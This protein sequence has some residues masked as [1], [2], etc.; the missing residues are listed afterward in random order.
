MSTGPGFSDDLV[1]RL[2]LPL[3]QLYRRA[4]AAPR[5]RER[6]LEGLYLWEAALRLLGSVALVRYAA[7][8]SRDRKVEEQLARLARPNAGL[9]WEAV[10]LLVPILAEHGDPY[11]A[12]VRTLLFGDAAADMPAVTAVLR[13]LGEGRDTGGP[14]GALERFF[15][16]LVA[17]RNRELGHGVDWRGSFEQ[18]A[19]VGGLLLQAAAEV[20]PRLDV[21]AGCRLLYLA[22]LRGSTEVAPVLDRFELVGEVPVRLEPFVPE[23]EVTYVPPPPDRLYLMAPDD[24]PPTLGPFRIRGLLPFDPL[25]HYDPE[26]G[27]VFFFNRGQG[28]RPP[29][30]TCYTT[31]R[32]TS[33][34]DADV[35][36]LPLL[37]EVLAIRP[38]QE[39]PGPTA[40]DDR[41]PAQPR[42]LSPEDTREAA[43]P[44]VAEPATAEP[45]T[46]AGAGGE[47]A[48]GE[49]A[50][51]EPGLRR[52]GE[53]EVVGELG[54]GNTGIVL[55]G[56][57]PVLERPVALK[58][59]PPHAAEEPRT[60]E[61]FLLEVRI[62]GRVRHPSLVQ[63]Y[64]SGVAEGCLFCAMEL[65]EGAPLSAVSPRLQ[66]G[67]RGPAG[68]DL[69]AWYRAVSDASRT[70]PPGNLEA[71]AGRPVYPR[72]AEVVRQVAGAAHALHRAGVVHR[73]MTP[74]NILIT[75]DGTRAVLIGLGLAKEGVE[76]GALTLEGSL[77]GTPGYA[78]PEQIQADEKR[79]DDRSDVYSL[80]V[81]LWELLTLRPLVRGYNVGEI[82]QQVLY[83]EPEPPR[84]HNSRVPADLEAVCLRCLH[85]DRDRRYASAHEL[86]EDL[87]RF[88]DGKPVRARRRSLLE[89]ATGWLRRPPRQ[90][91]VAPEIPVTPPS[92]PPRPAPE[93]EDRP[94]PAPP[95]ADRP[96]VP[97]SV[98]TPAPAPVSAPDQAFSS[99]TV[100]TLYPV[101][102]AIT[103]RR[104]CQETHPRSRL[105][106]LFF[107]L[108]SAVRYLLTLGVSDLFGVLANSGRDPAAALA[109]A[110]FEFLRRP[111]PMLLGK[112]VAALRETA[113]ALAAVPV[114]ERFVAELPEVCRPGGAL[115]ADLLAG[116]VSRRNDCAHPDGSIRL[117][118]E[119]CRELM[120]ECRPLLEEV[121]REVRFICRYPLGFVTPFAGLSAAPGE[122]YYHLHSCMGTWVGGTS[123]ALDLKTP[124]ELREELPFVAAPDG[125]R[126][127]Y[128]WPMLLQRR[129]EYTGR[130]T[131]FV[132]Q[133]IADHRRPFLASVRAA[134]VDVP[135]TWSPE[136]HPQPAASHAWLLGRL[137][138]LPPA[139][140]VPAELRLAERL[141]PARGGRLVGQEVG[142]N[143]LLSV[144]AVGGFGTVYAAEALDGERV[145]VKVIESRP[146]PVQLAR[147]GQEIARL[148]QAADHPGVIRLFEH[149]DVDV[150]GRICPWYSMEF[151]LGGD[152]RSR[153]DRRKVV[154]KERPPWDDPATRDEV[155]AE[156]TAVVEAVAHLH[157]LRIVHRDVKPGNVLI[158]G[159]GSLRLSD[160]GLVKNLQPSDETLRY[161]PHSA[162]GEGAGTPGYMAPE[163]ARGLDAREPAD[164]YALGILLAELALGE[165]PGAELP[166]A[167]PDGVTPSGSTLRKCRALDRLPAG[168]R[169]LIHR[170]TDADPEH[171]PGDAGELLREFVA[172]PGDA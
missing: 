170:C 31:G 69:R 77:V 78:S 129:S 110:D 3:A 135:E 112:W 107:V 153:I 41:G 53:F 119:K 24:G 85:K 144:V 105:E 101:P 70:F 114:N 57:Q 67:E 125:R 33:R 75:A 152:L 87:D 86:A 169:A 52:L 99:Q 16:A 45:V 151:A 142:S 113:R 130:R 11:F 8:S 35:G 161:G 42:R 97:R 2:P 1:R 117:P 100:V 17:Y 148:R 157:R 165:R 6:H 115:D 155:R 30:Y 121:L 21:L 96:T 19:R 166:P 154:A 74:H 140:E 59:L 71:M 68:P 26:T 54:R 143:R 73:N 18:Y 15:V 43:P 159:D 123:R 98:R 164:V 72:L 139:P 120:R 93:E 92:R 51:A 32:F 132:F 65:V 147:F 111:R 4:H 55:R 12:R 79:I 156:F 108:E 171:R 122:H 128:L 7:L 81:V 150:D 82:L 13:E 146:T 20:F 36:H 46:G 91:D 60:R 34:R 62:L 104:F 149:G 138:A 14:A 167:G 141:L 94:V 131:L 66:Q 168:L 58:Y 102:V 89:R 56:W 103:Y 48:T 63:V 22:N 64:G 37:G 160:F 162:T 134:A 39:A 133:E 27:E 116:L 88:L 25:V 124:I 38:P 61:R 90:D 145:A 29:E 136:L 76:G 163:Q 109:H 158:M 106:A 95:P 84:R 80:G 50:T 118:D 49:P 127:L 83:G 28:E 23:P 172:L 10:R 47:P 126:L 137:R 44:V 40:A 9:W 5:P